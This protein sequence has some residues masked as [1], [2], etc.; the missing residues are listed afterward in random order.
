MRSI[1][2]VS[3]H[4][5]LVLRGILKLSR[6]YI[7]L[8][9]SRVEPS[10]RWFMDCIGALDG[11][12]IQVTVPIEDQGRFRNR[13]QAITTNVL[14]VCDSNMKFLYVLSGWE[15]STSDSRVLRDALERDVRFEVP[16]GKITQHFF[17]K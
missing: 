5:K 17:E 6:D 16:N 15:G 3:R 11:T 7:K 9:E 10:L 12:H 8:P 1:D 14:G 13:K 4:F 2:T